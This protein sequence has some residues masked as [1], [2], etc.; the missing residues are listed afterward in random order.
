VLEPEHSR[1]R[2]EQVSDLVADGRE[3]L[4]G[5]HA[6][7]HQRGHPPQRRLLLGQPGERG[8][9]L[10]VRDRRRHQLRER[11]QPCL[12]VGRQQRAPVPDEHGAPRHRPSSAISSQ[13][14]HRFARLVA[15]VPR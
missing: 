11:G 6:L 13:A 9:A 4:R 14:Q 12:G 5:W 1:L 15:N 10:G 7:R 2:P 8:T 3:G